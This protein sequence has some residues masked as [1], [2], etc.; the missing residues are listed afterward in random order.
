M[1]FFVVVVFVFNCA[2]F[3]ELETAYFRIAD[4]V[5]AVVGYPTNNPP[6]LESM[7]DSM[8]WALHPLEAKKIKNIDAVL[9]NMEQMNFESNAFPPLNEPLVSAKTHVAFDQSKGIARPDIALSSINEILSAVQSTT[10]NSM[11]YIIISQS[12]DF[13]DERMREFNSY[14]P[15]FARADIPTFT[16]YSHP[17][18]FLCLIG[19][20]KPHKLFFVSM[21]HHGG[22]TFFVLFFTHE[23]THSLTYCVRST[24]DEQGT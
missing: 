15:F 21:L 20:P 16:P 7:F 11:E 23:F 17:K 5:V 22:T 8:L 2:C 4:G 6:L 12:A 14:L 18:K 13:R 19:S 10:K 24:S 9:Y 3:G 1:Y